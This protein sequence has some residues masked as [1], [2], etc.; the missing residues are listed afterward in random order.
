MTHETPC[1][2]RSA[3]VFVLT[4]ALNHL[5]AP[6]R[7]TRVCNDRHKGLRPKQALFSQYHFEIGP[8]KKGKTVAVA[9]S[10]ATRCCA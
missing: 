10:S 3:L 2:M 8:C 1:D 6:H 7:L 5:D 4:L 9:M